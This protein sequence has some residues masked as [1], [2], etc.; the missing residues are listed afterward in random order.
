LFGVAWPTTA[1]LLLEQGQNFVVALWAG[2]LIGGDSLTA[3]AVMNPVLTLIAMLTG[4]VHIGLQIV[5]ARA[6]G[7][8]SREAAALV[9]NGLYLG[10]AWSAA[11]TVLGLWQLGPLARTLAGDLAIVSS[12][13]SYFTPWLLFFSASVLS[14]VVMFAV[15]ATGWTRFGMWRSVASIIFMLVLMPVLIAVFDLGL[16]G[17]SLSDGCADLLLLALAGLALYSSRGAHEL[18]P[19]GDAWRIDFGMWRAIVTAGLPYQLVR[20]MMLLLQ[21]AMLRVLMTTDNAQLVAGYGIVAL[22]L[23]IIGGM[24][25]GSVISAAGIAIGQNVAAANVERASAYL[26]VAAQWLGGFGI[27]VVLLASFGEPVY[28]IFTD[29]AATVGHASSVM[30]LI[31]WA[32][33]AQLLAGLMLRANAAIAGNRRANLVSMGLSSIALV[34]A[35]ALPF[36]PL[37]R[38]AIVTVC[39]AYVQFA[40][41]SILVVRSL[42]LAKP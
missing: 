23:G 20:G 35:L 14:G 27:G 24:I 39:N 5:V 42:R 33:P 8:G 26:R 25:G 2:R 18:A 21:L 37:E 36:A 6:T 29:D 19:R 15:S 7:R 9:A 40:A 32:F 1:S 3:L 12:L 16:A 38:V 11:I 22:V 34:A 28:R 4:V 30:K 10:L 41:L 31:V 13:E 17:V